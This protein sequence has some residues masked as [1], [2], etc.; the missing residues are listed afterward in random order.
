MFSVFFWQ[1]VPEDVVSSLCIFGS[2]LCETVDQAHYQCNFHEEYSLL[3]LKGLMESWQ[4]FV[5]SLGKI[6]LD[7]FQKQSLNYFFFFS[8][9]YTGVSTLEERALHC[10]KQVMAGWETEKVLHL[11]TNSVVN[12][13]ILCLL[14][15]L[16]SVPGTISKLRKMGRIS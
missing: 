2:V 9:R 10:D 14:Q 7:G 6:F 16:L 11:P 13:P 4:M 15:P 3:Y 12:L 5:T 1:R 8:Y